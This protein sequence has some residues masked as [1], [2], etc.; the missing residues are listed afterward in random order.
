LPA[1]WF[2]EKPVNA[3]WNEK[4]IQIPENAFACALLG[5]IL[6]V[7]HN[8]TRKNTYGNGAVRPVKYS[9]DNEQVITASKLTGAAVERIRQRKIQR[10]DV[11]LA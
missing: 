6:L 10:I 7:Y 8:P 9:L 5:D 2:T 1:K 3:C 4:E 11:W